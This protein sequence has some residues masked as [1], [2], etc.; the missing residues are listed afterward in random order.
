MT[1]H[2]SRGPGPQELIIVVRTKAQT[3]QEE[4]SRID[5][6]FQTRHPASTWLLT[7]IV[8][9]IAGRLQRVVQRGLFGETKVGQFEDAVSF[10]RV[11]EQV[12]RLLGRNKEQRSG[13]VR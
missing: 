13:V 12:L 3:P 1:C 5:R 11:V 8:G 4:T 7:H 9:R 2:I 10:L 6:L